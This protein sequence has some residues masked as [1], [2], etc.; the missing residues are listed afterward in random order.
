MP[1]ALTQASVHSFM[2]EGQNQWDEDV[3]NDIC[4]ERDK[5]LIK[6]I[7]IPICEWDDSWFWLLDDKGIFT[8]KS[9]YKNIRGEAEFPEVSFWR[10]LW[11]LQLPGKVLNF[12]WRTCKEC[13]PTCVALARK[14]VSINNTCP[15]CQIYE[16]SIVHVLIECQ[17]A[18]EV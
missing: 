3:L 9:C 5:K 14:H 18:Q 16:E 12:L 8:V 6:Q 11:S 1:E 15:W 13:L 4:N 17:F 10:K 7:P 2:E